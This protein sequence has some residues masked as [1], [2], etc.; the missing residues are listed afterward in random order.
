[1]RSLTGAV[2]GWSLVYGGLRVWW[3]AGHAPS[4]EPFGSDLVGFTGWWSVGLCGEAGVLAVALH[5][6]RTWQPLLAAAAW[7][8]AGALIAAAAIL[9]P[10]IVGL[11]LLSLG[12]Q[13][14]PLGFAS[15]LGCAGGAVLLALATAA[16]QRRTRGD[17]QSC[18]R[19]GR[20]VRWH[21]WAWWAAYAA[22]AGLVARFV[23]QAVAGF[24][25]M[26]QG[27]SIIGLEV[28]MLLA[29]GLLPLA[30]V[31][32]WGRVWPRWVPLLAGRTI[33][34]LLLLIPGFGLGAGLVAYFGMGLLQVAS[35]VDSEFSLTFLLTA[36]SA[37]IVW[38]LGL[39]VAS[40][41]YHLRTR[42]SC[43][44]CGR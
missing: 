44:Q 1:M 18:C 25:G 20:P 38:G 11:L 21:R 29:G 13:F 35:G 41:D 36:M 37:Y 15:R 8:T 3:T 27:P 10:E 22:V 28:G 26:A 6:V 5:R 24:D 17:C 19:S 42:R 7:G 4:F 14:D 23:V 9:L 39:L 43:V 32:R 16:Y 30:L 34:R 31:H 2:V 12:P 40:T 33:P